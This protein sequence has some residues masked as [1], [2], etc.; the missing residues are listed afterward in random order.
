VGG[1]DI[2]WLVALFLTGVIYWGAVSMFP[3]HLGNVNWTPKVKL[4]GDV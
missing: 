1:V 3:D 2:S 4:E